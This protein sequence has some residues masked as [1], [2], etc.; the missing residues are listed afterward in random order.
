MS[1]FD[2]GPIAAVAKSLIT[3]FGAPAVAAIPGV[4]QAVV[5]GKP[6]RGLDADGAVNVGIELAVTEFEDSEIDGER[7]RR[8]DKQGWSFPPA[9]GEDL[10]Q[11]QIVVQ[12]GAVFRVLDV[13][14]VKPADAVLAYRLHLRV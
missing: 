7:I 8:T 5:A 9:G 4:S 12:G 6:W 13:I 1:R 3:T 10:S 2:F 11:A 14:V